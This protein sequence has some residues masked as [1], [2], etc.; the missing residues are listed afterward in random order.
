LPESSCGTNTQK[1]GTKNA[2][3]YRGINL[4]NTDYKVYASIIKNKLTD[5]YN[6]KIGE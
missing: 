4:L 2:E 3:N 1:R 5:Y 6:D